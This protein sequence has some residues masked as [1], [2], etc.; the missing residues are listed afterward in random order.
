[1]FGD[2]T[3]GRYGGKV[4]IAGTGYAAGLFWQ[5]ADDPARAVQ[6]AQG[7]AR[8]D[9]VNADFVCILPGTPTQ[10]GLGWKFSG[11][12]AGLRPLVA[13][14][15]DFSDG[16]FLGAFK[17]GNQY[18]IGTAQNGVVLPDG[19]ALYDEE[20]LAR[21]HFD[22]AYHDVN[23]EMAIYAPASWGIGGSDSLPLVQL[24]QTPPRAR[25]ESTESFVA[26]H[27][28]AFGFAFLAAF[29]FAGGMW[30]LAQQQ[31]IKQQQTLAEVQAYV[32]KTIN[33]RPWEKLPMAGSAMQACHRGFAEIT[34]AVPGWNMTGAS[35]AVNNGFAQVTSNWSRQSSNNSEASG[36]IQS[37][38]HA[39][40][41]RDVTL[42]LNT[43]DGNTATLNWLSK[44]KLP[45]RSDFPNETQRNPW[46]GQE[47]RERFWDLGN[48]QGIQI[49]LQGRD[50]TP[51]AAMPAPTAGQPPMA[52]PD[53]A[54]FQINLTS[55]VPLMAWRS[56]FD[57][58]PASTLDSVTY[59]SRNNNWTISGKLYQ[60]VIIP[61]QTTTP[62]STGQ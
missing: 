39:A 14:A 7:I 9:G 51:M 44:D 15:I 36:L 8:Q 26:Q 34:M 41:K 16:S 19:D 54:F 32:Q 57:A 23:A 48:R 28:L 29:G 4:T 11:H 31:Q 53:A 37:M 1:M 10:Y 50:S 27:K 17:I 43:Q 35:C 42:V 25:L 52:P 45:P 6:E 3:K 30:W 21:E 20:S 56:I 2:N 24:I 62:P 22:R 12:M 59:D 49:Q 13:A 5:P 58:V 18:W 33:T 47:I 38:R 46:P 55:T 61:A 40:A 60:Q